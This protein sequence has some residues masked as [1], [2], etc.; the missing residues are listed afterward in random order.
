M[1]HRLH[2]LEKVARG[3]PDGGVVSGDGLQTRPRAL[4]K[5]SINFRR[6]EGLMK[7]AVRCRGELRCADEC[8]FSD[9]SAQSWILARDGW[10]AND[11]KRTSENTHFVSLPG[12][13]RTCRFALQMSAYDPKR[14]WRAAK[15]AGWAFMAR[16]ERRRIS[17]LPLLG[18]LEGRCN[19]QLIQP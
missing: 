15:V 4:A 18:N 11:P 16:S 10:S 6:D 5:L 17:L 2:R 13:K 1:T 14:T 3:E 8:P 7:E 19:D 12:V 9:N